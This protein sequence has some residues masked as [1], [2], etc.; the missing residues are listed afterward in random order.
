MKPIMRGKKVN[1]SKVHR[2]YID[3]RIN[4]KGHQN[5]NCDCIS[6]T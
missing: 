4:K 1:Q 2:N 6:H 5:S 3:G